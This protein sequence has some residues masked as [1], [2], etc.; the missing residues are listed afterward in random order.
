MGMRPTRG[1]CL[2]GSKEG[3]KREKLRHHGTVWPGNRGASGEY[4]LKRARGCL[5]LE[6]ALVELEITL[7]TNMGD[8]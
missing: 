4:G 5:F 2:S 3:E 8:I 1:P 7:I 6:G